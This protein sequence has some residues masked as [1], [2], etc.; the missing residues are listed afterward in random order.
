MDR[1]FALPKTPAEAVCDRR[2]GDRQLM[3]LQLGILVSGTEHVPGLILDVGR[4]GLRF[5]SFKRPNMGSALRIT[6][7]GF[8]SVPCRLA[9]QRDDLLGLSFL[10]PLQQDELEKLL[11]TLA[12]T[13]SPRLKTDLK[14]MM[15]SG[16][17]TH[18]V[19]LL[20]ISPRG[21]GLELGEIELQYSS[22]HLRLP[23]TKGVDGQVRW[24]R[25]GRVG[26]AFNDALNLRQ[27]AEE[28]RALGVS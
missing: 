15:R 2:S 5:R 1:M 4:G 11:T 21:A 17:K 10:K 23:G 14:V 25:D 12:S 8:G 3:V 27:L 18:V 13:R 9:W 24:M 28:I 26:V 6:L 19:R 22:I 20:N 7:K 16:A